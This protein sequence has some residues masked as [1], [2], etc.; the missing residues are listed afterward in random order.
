MFI[1]PDINTTKVWYAVVKNILTDA[2]TRWVCC[3]LVKSDII[4]N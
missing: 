1:N 3:S 4:L 2:E